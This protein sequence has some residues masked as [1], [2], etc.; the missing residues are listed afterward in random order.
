MRTLNEAIKEE[1]DTVQY[2]QDKINYTKHLHND[3]CDQYI[4]NLIKIWTMVQ[5]KHQEIVDWLIE[6]R[7][8]RI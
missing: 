3:N 8:R 5:N 2:Y 6:L 4:L 1:Q 7:E